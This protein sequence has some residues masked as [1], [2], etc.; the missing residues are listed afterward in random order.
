MSDIKGTETKQIQAAPVVKKYPSFWR[1][2]GW[3]AQV[4]WS[5]GIGALIAAWA[6]TLSTDINIRQLQLIDNIGTIGFGLAA[7]L[8]GS[9]FAILS[10][11][12]KTR[13]TSQ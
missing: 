7:L 13:I 3:E 11:L 9:T 12:I 1:L 4:F 5:A 2:I 8:L 10:V 6:P